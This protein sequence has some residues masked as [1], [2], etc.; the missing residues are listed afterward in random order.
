MPRGYQKPGGGGDAK[1]K[2]LSSTTGR[3]W[4]QTLKQITTILGTEERKVKTVP[5]SYKKRILF[6]GSSS[7]EGTGTTNAQTK[8]YGKLLEAKLGTTNYEF[9]HRG[10]GGDNTPGA[11]ARFYRDVAPVN[12]DFVFLAFTIGN[13]G[14][15][16]QTTPAARMDKYRQ[17]KSGI[18]Q[19]CHMIQQQGAVPIVLTQAPTRSYTTEIYGYSQK[20]NAELEAMGIHCCDWGGV[21]DAM[22]GTGKPI[23]SIMF[24]NLHYNDA[25]HVE[26]ANAIPPTLFEKASLQDGGYLPFMEGYINTGNLVSQTPIVYAP[27]DITTFTY[28]MRFRK[29]TPDLVGLVSFN[30]NQRILIQANTSGGVM[31]YNGGETPT[32]TVVSMDTTYNFNDGL[33]HT[34]TV[35]YSPLDKN[36]K[37]Y[38]DGVLKSTIANTTLSLS[39]LTV[40][41]RD[42]T[43]ATLKNTDIKDIILYRTRL[44]AEK[45]QA[46]HEGTVSQTSL[47]IY[48]PLH[49]K[50]VAAN[51]NIINLAATNVNLQI[52]ETETALTAVRVAN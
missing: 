12:A 45:V 8:Y 4:T 29:S 14:I 2:D 47:E 50:I 3:W 36:L 38:V 16:G 7:T 26:M 10:V 9:F 6:L 17:F 25:A 32:P 5:L 42:G 22:D 1:T 23:D 28:S 35:S 13:E 30:A 49:D 37:V 20:M 46:L 39:K 48:S 24:D 33:W 21:V 31:Q 43:A 11:I 41:G 27:T 19:L 34:L 44:T 52:N 15:T 40:G 18:L 51:T